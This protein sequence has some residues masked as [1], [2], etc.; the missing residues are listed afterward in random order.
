M[1]IICITHADFESPGVITDWALSCGHNFSIYRPYTGEILGP[2]AYEGELLIMM[3]GPQSPLRL[4]EFPYL[5]DEIKLVQHYLKSQK[6]TIGF[7]LGA[8][9]IGEAL[10][11]KTEKS[12]EKE[13]GVFPI[14]LSPEGITT[15]YFKDLRAK[16]KQFI[17]IMT[18]LD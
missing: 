2:N 11:A 3:G 8:Q 7:C 13:I 15:L 5:K 18:C 9:L 1:K 16:L 4:S 6:P 17:G 10:G 12:P 14:F